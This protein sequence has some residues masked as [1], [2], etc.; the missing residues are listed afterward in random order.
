MDS[1]IA[2]YVVDVCRKLTPCRVFRSRSPIVY[3]RAE[4]VSVKRGDSTRYVWTADRHLNEHDTS[5]DVVGVRSMISIKKIKDFIGARVETSSVRPSVG[6]RLLFIRTCIDVTSV[7]PP[8]FGDP[9]VNL[10]PRSRSA[11][12]FAQLSLGA[13]VAYTQC[14]RFSSLHRPSMP[15]WDRAWASRASSRLPSSLP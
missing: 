5:V 7:T 9:Q 8:R 4:T 10:A 13:A 14:S 3:S 6:V 15:P 1:A 12:T 11:L 2:C